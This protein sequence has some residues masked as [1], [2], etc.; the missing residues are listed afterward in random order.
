MILCVF[1]HS[2]TES[3]STSASL[4]VAC[5]LHSSFLIDLVVVVVVCVFQFRFRFFAAAVR[6]R[7]TF[8]DRNL[9]VCS[10][11]NSFSFFLLFTLGRMVKNVGKNAGQS[12]SFRGWKISKRTSAGRGKI[13]KSI[14]IW[15]PWNLR[16]VDDVFKHFSH[17]CDRTWISLENKK[18]YSSFAATAD[19]DQ[20]TNSRRQDKW[21][22]KAR[23]KD[24]K[25]VK[26]NFN[27]FDFFCCFCWYRDDVQCPLLVSCTIVV[28]WISSFFYWILISSTFS[29]FSE[30]LTRPKHQT[31]SSSR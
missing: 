5:D 31:T 4:A 17:R 19:D 22:W 1:V 18:S 11:L 15:P 2:S 21:E 9:C 26:L 10:I 25:W 14:K 30:E 13:G 27:D 3:S 7:L 29:M 16:I 24:R 6:C 23:K 12:I 8:D 20:M 28:P